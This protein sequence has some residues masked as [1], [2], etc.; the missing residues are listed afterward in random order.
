MTITIVSTPRPIDA[1]FVDGAALPAG[2]L[3][4][5]HAPGRR[6]PESSAPEWNRD[7]DADLRHLR[8]HHGGDVLISLMEPEEMSA[9]GIAELPERAR[10]LGWEWRGFPIPDMDV[11]GDRAAF[12]SLLGEIRGLLDD[13]RC[14]ILHC[15]CGLGRSG[16]VAAAVLVELG[17]QAAEAIAAVRRARPGAIQTLD[18]ERL[19]RELRRD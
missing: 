14:V 4:L 13:G 3:G 18:Q 11:P 1:R 15:L 17:M 8:S 19:V 7:L 12:R 5:T 16:T 2:R 9:M 6:H 10:A